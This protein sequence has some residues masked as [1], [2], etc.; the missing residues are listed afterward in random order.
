M[1]HVNLYALSFSSS[2]LSLPFIPPS[3][4]DTSARPSP[5][6][7][8]PP[9]EQLSSQQK[10][11]SGEVEDGGSYEHE[12]EARDSGDQEHIQIYQRKRSELHQHRPS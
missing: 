8:S 11:E 6:R 4:I 10:S 7:P 12:T 1:N 3:A 9:E 5:P 2:R